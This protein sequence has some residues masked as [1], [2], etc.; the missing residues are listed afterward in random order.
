MRAGW[1][2]E[3]NRDGF[4]TIFLTRSCLPPISPDSRKVHAG[5]HS[6]DSVT[7][8]HYKEAAGSPLVK[9]DTARKAR[10]RKLCAVSFTSKKLL[11]IEQHVGGAELNHDIS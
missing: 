10:R 6:V 4:Y 8:T 11:L 9:L 7:R 5:A 1:T 3:S 2:D